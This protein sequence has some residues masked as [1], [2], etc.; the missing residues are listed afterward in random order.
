MVGKGARDDIL[1]IQGRDIMRILLVVQSAKYN[2]KRASAT[3]VQEGYSMV[4]MVLP[5][6]RRG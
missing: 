4:G 2:M 5:F 3:A 1:L 6:C